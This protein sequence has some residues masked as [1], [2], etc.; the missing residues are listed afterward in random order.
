MSRKVSYVANRIEAF[1]NMAGQLPAVENSRDSNPASSLLKTSPT[2]GST[3]LG[4][5]AQH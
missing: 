3:G 1:G 5:V 2:Q 4:T